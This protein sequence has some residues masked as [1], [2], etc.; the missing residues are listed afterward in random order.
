MLVG[1]P[2]RGRPARPPLKEACSRARGGRFAPGVYP[3][4]SENTAPGR[5]SPTV[6]VTE[7]RVRMGWL[8]PSVAMG[9]TRA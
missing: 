6:A 9:D 3:T 1:P 8:R 4:L 5:G 7:Q 2:R